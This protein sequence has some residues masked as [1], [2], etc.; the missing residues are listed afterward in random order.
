MEPIT[1]CGLVIVMFGVWVEF[2][3][4][5]MAVVRAIANSRID[6]HNRQFS[7]LPMR[8]ERRLW[9]ALPPQFKA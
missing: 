3:S 4:T 1:L 6:F 2:E 5:V 9:P 8:E 7:G